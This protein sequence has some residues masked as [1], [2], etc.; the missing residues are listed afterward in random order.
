[1]SAALRAGTATIRVWD[2]FVR[3][4]H[5]TLA[6]SFAVAWLSG[7][8]PETLHNLAG[9]AAGA[10]VLARI[11]WGFFGPG[12]ARFSQFVRSPAAVV[13]YLKSIA[14]GSERRFIGHNPA[15]GA[16][17]V[18]LLAAVAATAA[19]GWMLTMDTFWGSTSL[20]RLHSVLAHG[21][22]LLVVA[23]FFGVVLASLRHR[24]NLARAMVIGD[25]RAPGPGD[26]A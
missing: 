6:L 14:A 15:G 24:E 2:P 26:V 19:T 12:Y 7:E 10:L 21:V 5:W 13:D 8:G 3:T 9:Y 1:M 17:V 25:K 18:V 16:M 22:L 4:F 11:A 23:H 20:Q